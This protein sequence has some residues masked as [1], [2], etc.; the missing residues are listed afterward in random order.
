[1]FS[2]STKQVIG[3]DGYLQAQNVENST[4]NQ[5]GLVSSVL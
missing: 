3:S 4:W 2:K 5:L 1:M